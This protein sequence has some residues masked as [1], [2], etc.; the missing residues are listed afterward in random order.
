MTT[1]V[2]TQANFADALK[3]LIE[4]DYDAVDAYQAAIDRLENEEYKAKLGK[5]KADHESHI[6]V[7]NRI[8]HAHDG[9]IVESGGAKGWL[10]KGKV[11]LANL[12]GDKTILKAMRSNEEDTNTAYKKMNSH[13]AKWTDAADAIAQGMEDEEKHKKWLDAILDD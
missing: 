2:G 7:L 1:L 9:V 10:T 4:L 3:E 12:I 13:K 8:L 11:I 6:K 5:F